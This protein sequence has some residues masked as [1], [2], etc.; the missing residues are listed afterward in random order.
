MMWVDT[1][2]GATAFVATAKEQDN[3]DRT[4]RDQYR[5]GSADLYIASKDTLVPDHLPDE[6]RGAIINWLHE[7]GVLRVGKIT[8][9]LPGKQLPITT[10]QLCWTG[11]CSS[12]IW[13]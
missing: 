12:I 9:L 4:T 11:R 5:I 3:D 10:D 2:T 7:V 1:Q 13:D 8:L 6:L